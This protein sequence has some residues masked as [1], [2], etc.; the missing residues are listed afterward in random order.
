VIEQNG[1]A[2]RVHVDLATAAV[3]EVLLDLTAQ[4]GARLG[5]H[6]L[7]ELL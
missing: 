7:R 4:L 6:V 5:V 2:N 3:C 1:L